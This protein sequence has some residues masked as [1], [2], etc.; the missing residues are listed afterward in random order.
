[1]LLTFFLLASFIGSGCS[2]GCQV[3]PEQEQCDESEE[4]SVKRERRY[5]MGIQ[6]RVD[7]KR[8]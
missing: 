1:M 4:K 6:D 2:S 5:Q 3:S 7:Q 8:W